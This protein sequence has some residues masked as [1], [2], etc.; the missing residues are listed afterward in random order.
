MKTTQPVF[1]YAKDAQDRSYW[2]RALV[3]TVHAKFM[4][5]WTDALK[6]LIPARID[7]N[8]EY[9][10]V[11]P[12]GEFVSRVAD[13][14]ADI[15]VFEIEALQCLCAW[16]MDLRWVS[17]AVDCM[18]GGAG[19]LPMRTWNRRMSPMETGIRQRLLESLATAYESGWQA[20]YPIRLQPLRQEEHVS[21]LRLLQPQQEVLWASFTLRFNEVVLAMTLCLPKV[22]IDHLLLSASQTLAPNAEEAESGGAWGR[23]L[24]HQL[25]STPVQAVAVLSEKSL[26]VAQLMSLS[27]G[28]VIPIDLNGPVRMLVDNTPVLS[29]KYGVRNGKYA[30]KVEQLHLD[31]QLYPAENHSQ[32]DESVNN[33]SIIDTDASN[34]AQEIS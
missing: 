21:G 16:A 14:Q 12:Y 24:R 7:I 34:N 29:G 17:T 20:H 22:G 10:E 2:D 1:P 32:S 23:G 9:M 13:P 27:I 6:R 4:T 26:S 33:H 8:L 31:P 15:Q 28:Q 30:V 19:R 3:E 18:F 11:M 5:E 25:E